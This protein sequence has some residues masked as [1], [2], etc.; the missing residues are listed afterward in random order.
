M[1]KIF[2]DEI[3]EL[4][5][6]WDCEKNGTLNPDDYTVASHKKIWWKCK[7]GHSWQ[8]VISNRT[9][10]RQGC[11]YCSGLLAI[12]GVNDLRTVLPELAAEWNYDK[13]DGLSPSDLKPSSQKKV[14]WIC[15]HGHSWQAS[16]CNRKKG[17]GCPYC[18]GRYPIQGVND[19][20]TLFPELAAE[21]DDRRN[22][23]LLP[24]DVTAGSSRN[25][26]WEAACGHSWKTTVRNRTKGHGC[27]Y[28]SGRFPLP[29]INDLETIFPILAHEWDYEKNVNLKP[30]DVKPRSNRKVWWRCKHGHCWKTTVGRRVE[31]TGC[32]YCSGRYSIKG[33]NDLETLFPELALEWDHEKNGGLKPSDV[34][35]GSALKVW[36][37][38]KQGH[39]WE[40]VIY[41]RN[42][43]CGCPY[44]A[45]QAILSGYNDLATQR[46]ALVAEWDFEKNHPLLPTEVGVNAEQKVWWRCRLGHSW[47]AVIGNRNNGSGCHVCTGKLIVSGINDLAARFPDIASQWD[48]EKNGTLSPDCVAPYSGRKIW[49][50]CQ[51]G[52]SWVA[53]IRNRT[54]GNDCP[55]CSNQAVLPGYNDLASKKPA[56]AG[57]WDSEK[58]GVLTPEMITV[59]SGRIVWW[60]C[61]LG[62]SWRTSVSHRHRGSSCPYCSGRKVLKGFN[63][64]HSTH[65]YLAA[66]WDSDK[67]GAATP[68]DFYIGSTMRAWWKCDKGH[69][70]KAQIRTRMRYGCP[71]CAGQVLTGFNDLA[72]INP[73]LA[74]GWD[75][76]KNGDLH[77]KDVSA[78]SGEK[79]WW[80]CALGHQWKAV[81][82]SRNSG[83]GCP[84]CANKAVLA[85]Y[86]DLI[87]LS[88]DLLKEWDYERNASVSPDSVTLFSH[89][90]V[91]WKCKR[92]HSWYTAI[93][94][95]SSGSGCPICVG[96]RSWRP[97]LVK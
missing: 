6:E 93:S 79:V 14:W 47:Q 59:A 41:S 58:N 23:G 74:A 25:V 81:I 84:Y 8:A 76:E 65:P 21:W 82:A 37:K 43:G 42:N 22:G 28:C 67:N 50:R 20:A 56:F 97:R 55:Y 66:E 18:S 10:G 86:N 52:H 54:S 4:A 87:T 62:H 13:N 39:S 73:A 38:C 29:G 46:P 11:P 48:C 90:R 12:R 75:R 80:R 9:Y 72:T 70:W 53:A 88:P 78:N 1:R 45:N 17:K 77:P 16:V 94:D 35:L 92:G 95:R 3:P 64:I 24:G 27:P 40:A 49:W 83:N 96:K 71:Y 2:T 7:L 26:W 36:W 63:D 61:S 60:R 33:V 32:P 34:K 68:E 30:S 44:C 19:L 57:E 15:R 91:W 51:N 85:G 69:S 31:G 89:H 5:N